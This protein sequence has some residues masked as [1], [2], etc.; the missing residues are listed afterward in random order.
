MQALEPVLKQ[1]FW[2]L[3]GMGILMTFIGWWMATGT[4]AQA[5]TERKTKIEAAEGSIPKGDIPNDNWTKR[6]SEV[7]EKQDLS[8]KE[9]QLGL[10]KRQFERM[11]LPQGLPQLERSEV[12]QGSPK[13]EYLGT[14]QNA[15]RELFRDAYAD[16]VRKVWK[17]LNPMDVDGTGVVKFPLIQ[18]F[19][20]MNQKQWIVAPPKSEIIWE[21]MED[22]WL[23]EGLF[24]S[25]AEV[26][27]GPQANRT[28]AV[29]H[30]IDK[31]EL[32]GGGEKSA[33]GS[34]CGYGGGACDLAMGMGMGMGMGSGS[35]SGGP[36]RGYPGSEMPG[37][38]GAA[39]SLP[40]VSAEFDPKE[41]I[42]DDGSGSGSGYG[43]GGFGGGAPT[44][45]SYAMGGGG[46][47]VEAAAEKVVKRYV[48]N[49]DRLPYKTRGFYLSVKMD[50]RRIPQ[51]LAELTA[52]DKSVWPV[53]ILRV[54]MSRL[55]EDDSTSSLTPGGGTAEYGSRMPPG[56]GSIGLGGVPSLPGNGDDG[57]SGFVESLSGPAA[58]SAAT[59][60]Q[61]KAAADL[62]DIALK[63][64]Y[65]AQVTVCGV[66]TIYRKVEKPKVEPAIETKP[67]TPTPEATEETSVPESKGAVAADEK[68]ITE[69]EAKES[70]EQVTAPA[71]EGNEPAAS[72]PASEFGERSESP[73]AKAT[74]ENNEK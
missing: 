19:K 17:M 50:H 35:G 55:H 25:I 45:G 28:E 39:A 37:L 60:L 30:Q 67:A 2:I 74:N 4:I 29:I 8:I 54:Q 38:G 21:V 3:L 41:E 15:D 9:T 66:F 10:W 31:L 22:L 71:V 48:S 1:K 44:M 23:L 16:E 63:D 5:I 32:R 58:G 47:V 36:P 65:M 43:G 56:Q 61:Q 46:G 62:L 72:E 70:A 13:I 12:P 26:N 64:P 7:N 33:S 40:V 51:L 27:G 11:E 6:L 52:N 42:G 14:F 59:F 18:M 57:V 73:P 49:E 24:Q 34:S 53:E 68:A 20:V 69:T